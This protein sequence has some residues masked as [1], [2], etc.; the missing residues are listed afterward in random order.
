MILCYGDSN[1]WGYD[2]RDFLGG[3][4]EDSWCRLLER[5]LGERV[6][7]AGEN[8]RLCSRPDQ[9]LLTALLRQHQPRMLV[10]MLG[11]NDV[12]RGRDMT[13]AAGA[14]EQL[15]GRAEQTLPGLRMLVLSPPEMEVPGTGEPLKVLAAALEGAARRQGAAFAD[16]RSWGISL[17]FD[18]V[19]FSEEG[20][21]AFAQALAPLIR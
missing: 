17:S 7:N 15:L 10:V 9:Q 3:P 19:H 6:L 1:T 13:G 21:R 16:C 18:G 11:T 12:L 5:S 2:P 4:V 8:G 14:M 20:H